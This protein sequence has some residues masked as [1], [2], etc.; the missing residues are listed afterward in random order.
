VK[1]KEMPKLIKKF[2]FQHYKT[3]NNFMIFKIK[4][5]KFMD[6]NREIFHKG[7]RFNK[8]RLEFVGIKEEVY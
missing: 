5:A 4:A 1:R 3:Y 6:G 8:Q 2:G 7:K